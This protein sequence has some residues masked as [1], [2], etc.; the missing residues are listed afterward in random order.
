[1]SNKQL[2]DFIASKLKS[3]ASSNIYNNVKDLYDVYVTASL[4]EFDLYQLVESIGE[5]N[6]ENIE[7]LSSTVDRDVLERNYYK[8]NF[9]NTHPKPDF[10]EVFCIVRL[11]VYPIYRLLDG[12]NFKQSYWDTKIW[13]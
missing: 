2:G 3:L 5:L 9:K 13:R 4:Y 7:I 8:I 10:D 6:F 1:M 11:F 12:D